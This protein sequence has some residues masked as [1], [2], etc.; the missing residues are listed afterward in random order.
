MPI[1]WFGGLDGVTL[2]LEAALTTASGAYGVFDSGLF[3]TALFGPDIVW[4]D[5]STDVRG[6]S[7]SR[8]FSRDVAAWD[9]GSAAFLL[10]NRLRH[11]SP[12]N[13]SS[14]S[15]FVVGGVSQIRPLRQLRWKA[16]YAGVT[17]PVYQG[18]AQAWEE[19]FVPGHVDGFVT[20]PCLDEM[21]MLS[22]FDGVAQTPAGAGEKSGQRIH[23]VLDNARYAGARNVELGKVTLQATTLAANAT[24]ELKLTADSEGG[25]FWVDTDGTVM[26]AQ[27]YALIENL[28]S[29]TIQATFGDGSGGELPCSDIAVAYNGDLVRNIVSYTRVGGTAQ[30]SADDASRQVYRDRRESRTDLVCETDAQALGLAEFF[31]AQFKDPE[32]RVTQ[33]KVKPRA[34]PAALFPVV[35]GLQVRDLV[36]V[37]VRPLGGGTITRDCHIS[38]ISHRVT[39]DDWETTFDLASASVY[40][41]YATSRFDV[42]VFDTATFFFGSGG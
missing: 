6:L 7:S 4:S 11:Y 39:G 34:K 40:Q 14:S 10:D 31:V 22:A 16:T 30:L 36:R 17:Y 29:N 2:T 5:I 23:R 21:S 25:A 35:L 12:S 42:G 27:Q 1:S 38:G 20:V 9:P 13:L 26:F 33:I 24:A 18:Y 8:R 19:T 15:P 32:Q 41:T 28:R 3:D 37:V